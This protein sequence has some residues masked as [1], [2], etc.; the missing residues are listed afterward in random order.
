MERTDDERERQDK[1]TTYSV[2]TVV[3]E[4][5]S[6][7]KNGE[8]PVRSPFPWLDVGLAWRWSAVYG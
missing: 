4:L 6:C 5:E 7:G 3:V 8:C 2:P 1:A